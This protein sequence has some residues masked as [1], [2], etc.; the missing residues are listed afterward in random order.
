MGALESNYLKLRGLLPGQTKMMA[1]VKAN[2]Y[3]HGDVEAARLFEG[4]GCEFLGVAVFEEGARL[5]EAGISR[6]VVLLG[7]I[8]PGQAEEA[9]DLGLTPVV[10][11]L[12][13]AGIIDSAAKKKRIIKKIHVKIDTGMGRLG[14]LPWEVAPF[15]EGLKALRNLKVEAVLSHFAESES[16]EKEFSRRQLAAF[17]KAVDEIRGMGFAP[18]FIEMANSAALVDMEQAR[19]NLVRPGIMLYGS[20]PAERLREQIDLRPVLSL[21]T[22]IL[23]L[24]SVPAGSSVSYG[25]RFTARRQ[26][27]IA[28][29]PIG[30]A[31][32]L[33][34]SL[35]GSGEV[36]VGGRR[37]PI[38]GTVCMDLCMADVTDVP[39]VK[40]GDEVVII[41][42]QGNERITAEEVASRAGTISYE[43]FCR[44]SSRVPR[45]Y[46]KGMA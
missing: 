35:G 23:H 13:T 46:Y 25:R 40:T 5:R 31:D 17:Q 34:R 18:R 2:A 24:K 6:P 42:S 30:Y 38:A 20:Y 27:L 37:A 11:D 10:F 16:E 43:I 44:I 39:G 28:T 19:L 7:G 9:L 32:G 15:F 41:G 1:V 36:L 29:L 4:L 21:T 45:V 22:R 8:F 12:T 26:S 33:P 3:G 14:L